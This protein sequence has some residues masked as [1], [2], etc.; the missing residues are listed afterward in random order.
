LAN[1]IVALADIAALPAPLPTLR[2][3]PYLHRAG[4]QCIPRPMRRKSSSRKPTIRSVS[5]NGLS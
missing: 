5:A 3:P 4:E 1:A 2:K